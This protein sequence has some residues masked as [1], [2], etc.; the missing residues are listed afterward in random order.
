MFCPICNGI[1]S[2]ENNCSSCG[3]VAMDCGRLSDWTGPYAPYEPIA[4]ERLVQPFLSSGIEDSCCHVVY[5][6]VCEQVKEV[7][8]REWS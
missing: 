7:Y 6:S 2:Y 5:C 3:N 4:P 8:I 1:V